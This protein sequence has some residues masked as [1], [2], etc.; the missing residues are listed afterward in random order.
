M[1]SQEDAERIVEMGADPR[2]VNV[3][4]NAKYDLLARKAGL[5]VESSIRKKLNLHSSQPVFVAGSTREGEEEIV[6]NVY[7]RIAK[8]FPDMVL[9]LAPRHI[10]RAPQIESLLKRRKVEYQ[11]RS[12]IGEDGRLR[13]KPVLLLD[14]FGELFE[15][16]SVGSVNYC[17][18]SLVPLGGQNPLEAAVWGKPVLYGPHMEDFLD[19]KS[20]LENAGAGIEV[21][22]AEAF[23]EKALWVLFHPKEAEDCGR[24][25]REAIVRNQGAA[26][27]HTDAIWRLL[28]AGAK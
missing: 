16:Y 27:K 13:T 17:G 18:A 5:G 14:T 2:K 15:L 28:G 19:A 21:T 9:I 3:H 1:I 12:E 25:A 22:D 7:D 20:L 23:A 11:L 26:E 10:V 6:L 8:H 24:R 4:G